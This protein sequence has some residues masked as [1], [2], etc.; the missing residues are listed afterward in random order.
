MRVLPKPLAASRNWRRRK[1]DIIINSSRCFVSALL[2]SVFGLCKLS[3]YV[4]A[5]NTLKWKYIKMT[6][7]DRNRSFLFRSDLLLRSNYACT[8][9]ACTYLLTVATGQPLLCCRATRTANAKRNAIIIVSMRRTSSRFTLKIRV[10]LFWR[11]SQIRCWMQ[12]EI[13]GKKNETQCCFT[14]AND[15]R[16]GLEFVVCTCT[17]SQIDMEWLQRSIDGDG[18][19]QH[20]VPPTQ[21]HIFNNNSAIIHNF[22]GGR[23]RNTRNLFLPRVIQWEIN[24]NFRI[25]EDEKENTRLC[26][27][28]F[29]APPRLRTTEVS[30]NK[31]C[32]NVENFTCSNIRRCLLPDYKTNKRNGEK[33]TH[34]QTAE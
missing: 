33:K 6:Q 15:V 11:R 29:I 26:A 19:R 4:W 2:F 8:P 34:A 22:D 28:E 25:G 14:S 23:N 32:N 12:N 9:V 30:E 31:I 10:F 16:R 5:H 27:S 20:P 13:K 3:Y 21:I 1:K 18:T 24:I 7:L 17:G